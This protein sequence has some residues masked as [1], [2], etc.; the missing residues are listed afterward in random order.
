MKTGWTTIPMKIGNSVVTEIDAD[1]EITWR[2]STDEWELVGVDTITGM[3]DVG[4]HLDA[5]SV[6]DADKVLRV[7]IANAA[8]AYWQ[9]NKA[10]ILAEHGLDEQRTYRDSAPIYGVG[11]KGGRYA[12]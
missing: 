5:Q 3:I 11:F 7:A 10:T 8:E 2:R 1:L 12:A 4:E 6:G 9:A